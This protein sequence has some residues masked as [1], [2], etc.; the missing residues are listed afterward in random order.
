MYKVRIDLFAMWKV[1][2]LLLFSIHGAS[3]LG[4]ARKERLGNEPIPAHIPLEAALSWIL[5]LILLSK[6]VIIDFTDGNSVNYGE[7]IIE[8]LINRLT[9]P[10]Y[11][12]SKT[13][14]QSQV[15]VFGSQISRIIDI[16]A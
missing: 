15:N 6:E 5:E 11:M 7:I 14:Q 12:A 1:I 3:L 2:I 16:T 8:R 10:K 13:C 9:E 4:I